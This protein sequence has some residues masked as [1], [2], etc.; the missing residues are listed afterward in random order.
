MF[1][2]CDGHGSNGDQA[3]K[4]VAEELN[5]SIEAG[6]MES[7]AMAELLP[8]AFQTAQNRLKM[9]SALSTAGDFEVSGTTVVVVIICRKKMW[10]AHA[11]DSRAVLARKDGSILQLTG[12]HN[13]T[14]K[15]EYTRIFAH[16]G[17]IRKYDDEAPRVVAYNETGQMYA[18]GMSRSVGDLCFTKVGVTHE[19]TVSS[20]TIEHEDEWIIMASDGIWE[21]ITNRE[22]VEIVRKTWDEHKSATMCTRALINKAKDRWFEMEKI[23][24]D[25]ITVTM[26]HV[27]HLLIQMKRTMKGTSPKMASR[28]GGS[29]SLAALTAS[30]MLPGSL[31]SLDIEH[32]EMESVMLDPPVTEA[33][34]SE[35]KGSLPSQ[36]LGMGMQWDS[37]ALKSQNLAGSR[38]MRRHASALLLSINPEDL[39]QAPLDV[40]KTSASCQESPP[41]PRDLSLSPELDM[42]LWKFDE[43]GKDQADNP[44]PKKTNLSVAAL[45]LTAD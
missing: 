37:T 7:A 14:L 5:A 27:P 11:G 43:L 31:G 15:S 2:V 17:E 26:I 8:E 12:D 22:A 38:F 16:G 39:M 36:N 21:F 18:L 44:S 10:M 41:S 19:P 40:S 3:S 9:D 4:R 42:N 28:G 20:R 33:E 30:P 25:D 34:D 32:Q 13:V 6:I 1:T 24:R 23:Y 29:P 45:T 35:L